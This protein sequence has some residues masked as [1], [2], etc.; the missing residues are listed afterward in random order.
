MAE[1]TRFQLL[2]ERPN[3]GQRPHQLATVAGREDLPQT[4]ERVG[5][6]LRGVH[7]VDGQ[8]AQVSTIDLDLELRLAVVAA[9]GP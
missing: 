6:E 7:L 2:L 8:L 9:Y 5:D 3:L 1:S 4:S